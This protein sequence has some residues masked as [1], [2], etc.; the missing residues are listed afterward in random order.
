ME[1]CKEK[2]DRFAMGRR[3]RAVRK[4]MGMTQEK[5]ADKMGNDRRYIGFWE[6]GQHWTLDNLSDICR[7]TGVSA[8]FILGL[9]DDFAAERSMTS[10]EIQAL[11]L[12][13]KALEEKLTEEQ[14]KAFLLMQYNALEM[15]L[16][17]PQ[18][19]KKKGRGK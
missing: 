17:K 11:A 2:E 12:K 9:K 16:R 13:N 3:L 19:K 6:N 14:M 5:L 18:E 15:V 7:A 1:E 8:D 10:E 4:S